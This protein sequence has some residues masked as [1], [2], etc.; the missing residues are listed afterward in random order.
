MVLSYLVYSLCVAAFIVCGFC[1]VSLC[2]DGASAV[3]S[4]L[5]IIFLRKRESW[6]LYFNSVVTIC[7]LSQQEH[8][9]AST[10]IQC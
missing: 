9:V 4:S 8:N 1:V 10:L 3:L 7:I 2:C 5:V 6:L